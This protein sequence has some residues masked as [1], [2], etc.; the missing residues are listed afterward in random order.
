MSLQ[1]PAPDD[2]R[3]L[4][5]LLREHDLSEL[6]LEDASGTA[7]RRLVLRRALY[8]APTATPP[9]SST[10]APLETM[11]GANEIENVLAEA[12]APM[13]VASPVVGVFRACEPAIETGAIVKIGQVLGFVESLKV[14]SEVRAPVAGKVENVGC[15]PG[16]GVEY[17]QALF[18]IAA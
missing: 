17:G 3:A 10:L 9:A 16:Q 6:S 12:P 7:P 8:A 1:L 2:V 11:T 5:Q 18:E 13:I 15:E 14:P 4:A